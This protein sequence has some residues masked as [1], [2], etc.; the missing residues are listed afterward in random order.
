MGPDFSEFS[1]GF[2]FTQE[3]IS[4]NPG[5]VKAP[6][7]PSLIDEAQKGFDLKLD[8]LGH[9]KFFQFKLSAYMDRR[10]TLHWCHHKE[11][12]FR[13][14]ISTKSKN[15]RPSQHTVLKRLSKKE[16][17]VLYVAPRFH[18]QAQFDRF[19]RDEKITTNSLWAPLRSLP[20]EPENE[21]HYMTFTTNQ[22]KP[23]WHS[24]KTELTGEFTAE[25]HYA[26]TDERYR[27]D[28]DYFRQLRSTLVGAL[29]GS[30]VREEREQS[31]RDDIADVLRD[32]HRLLTVEFGLHLA[33]LVEPEV[34]DSLV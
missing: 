29:S 28:E 22:N 13:V 30:S 6:E 3:Y 18:S 15:R 25:E 23:D 14:R 26:M 5:L 7:L 4:R 2:A 17:N 21:T 8:Y 10:G 27:I 16:Q 33:L 34:S 12:H 24:E 20:C 31:R 11:P 19:Y 1:Y 32:V 9:A